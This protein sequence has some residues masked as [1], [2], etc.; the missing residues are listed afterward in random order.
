MKQETTRFANEWF[1]N[2]TS[3][4]VTSLSC[5]QILLLDF[6]QNYVLIII[7]TFKTTLAFKRNI[8]FVVFVKSWKEN[9]LLNHYTG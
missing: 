8:S 5:D 9:L 3:I 4:N 6:N 7:T 1:L 2:C